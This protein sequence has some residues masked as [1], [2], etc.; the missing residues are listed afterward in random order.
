MTENIQEG[1]L[2]FI[3][4]ATPS[5]HQ[6]WS[7]K[8]SGLLDRARGIFE[9]PTIYRAEAQRGVRDGVSGA[10]AVLGEWD[11]RIAS[12]AKAYPEESVAWDLHD[13]LMS[14]VN[15]A[16]ESGLLS[17]SDLTELRKHKIPS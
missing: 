16:L 7:N 11:Q 3:E 2:R 4:A 12:L 8:D 5:L 13:K 1:R 9:L 14:E 15:G 10:G 17:R 6:D